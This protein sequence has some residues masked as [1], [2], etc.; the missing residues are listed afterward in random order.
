MNSFKGKVFQVSE[1]NEFISLYLEEV[2]EVVVEGEITELKLSQGKWVFL[3]LKDENASLPVFSVLYKISTFNSLAEGMLVKVRGVA[4][5]HQKSGRFSLFA[6]S[7][8]PSGE[9]ALK[10]A[11]EQLRRKLEEEGLFA[12]ARKR[13]LTPFPSQIAFITA[14]DSQAQADFLKILKHR[15][16]GLTIHFLPIQVQGSESVKSILRAF[17][18]LEANFEK[19]D[20]VV[21][22]RGGGSLE[23]LAS[24]NDEAVVRRI[25]ASRFPVV[26]GVGHENDWTL[27]DL[28]AD[29]RASTPSN[30]AELLVFSREE[31][32][33]KIESGLKHLKSKIDSEFIKKKNLIRYFG[34]MLSVHLRSYEARLESLLRVLNSLDYQRVLKRGYSITLDSKGRVIRN[35]CQTKIRESI[36]TKLAEGQITSVVNKLNHEK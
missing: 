20:A 18:Y 12:P 7:I 14:K 35:S 1:F 11:L 32:L 2:G 21:L 29:V 34:N 30:A 4:R 5:L 13:T 9:G 8:L 25:F 6:E 24:F 3:T 10:A 36:I 22:V 19:L 16:G 17:D 33:F 27:A 31:L 28:V 23:D 26:T 15:Q